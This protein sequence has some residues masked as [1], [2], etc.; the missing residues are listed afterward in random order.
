MWMSEICDSM[1]TQLRQGDQEDNREEVEV[2]G[3]VSVHSPWFV[4]GV[5]MLTE[6]KISKP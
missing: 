6:K 1:A 2:K 3:R 5:D 4:W